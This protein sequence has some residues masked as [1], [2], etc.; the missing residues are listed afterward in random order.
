MSPLDGMSP[1]IS[2]TFNFMFV[3][4][5]ESNILMHPFD[6]SEVASVFSGLLFLAMQVV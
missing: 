5:T 6:I 3:F 4:Q 1:E 2:G